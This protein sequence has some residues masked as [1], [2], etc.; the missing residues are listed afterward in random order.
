MVSQEDEGGT[1]AIEPYKEAQTIET[2][3]RLDPWVADRV[4]GV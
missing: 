1:I 2:L 3:E 4:L